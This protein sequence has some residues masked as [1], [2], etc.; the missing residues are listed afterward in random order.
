MKEKKDEKE[1]HTT[2]DPTSTTA[3]EREGLAKEAI[4]KSNHQYTKPPF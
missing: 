2:E 3:E 4:K 1:T